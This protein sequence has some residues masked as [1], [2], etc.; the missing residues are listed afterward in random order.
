MH[1]RRIVSILFA[2][3]VPVEGVKDSGAA[4]LATHKEQH[5]VSTTERL[6]SEMN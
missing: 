3:H 4:S 2:V 5:D 6:L 1:G